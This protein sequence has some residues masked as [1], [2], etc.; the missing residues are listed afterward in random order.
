MYY[1]SMQSFKDFHN[2]TNLAF[3]SITPCVLCVCVCVC[4]QLHESFCGNCFMDRQGRQ[5][6]RQAN[7]RRILST[8]LA[9]IV[10]QHSREHKLFLFWT[11]GTR[12]S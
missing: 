3:S 4:I 9:R 5:M 1:E 6:G 8:Q 12:L 10:S 2:A 11:R 7:S